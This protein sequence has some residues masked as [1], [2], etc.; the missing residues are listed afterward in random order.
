MMISFD[1]NSPAEAP[2]QKGE[3]RT[4][5]LGQ[6]KLNTWFSENIAQARGKLHTHCKEQQI[7]YQ[8]FE[9]PLK[10]P[11]G[12][13]LGTDVVLVGKE[14][15]DNLL[16][17]VSGTHGV[18]TLVGSG[19]QL[20]WLDANK[21]HPLPGNTAVLIIHGINP[22]GAAWRSRYTE[23]NVDLNRNF[24]NHNADYPP[25]PD[26]VKLHTALS[27]RAID[28]PEKVLAEQT[29]ATFCKDYGEKAYVR[30]L[31]QG[32]YTHKDGLAFGGNSAT[33]SNRTLHQILDIYARHAKRIAVIDYHS[34]IGPYGYG[35]I[36]TRYKEG[37]PG[38]TRCRQWY[39][40][41][42][43]EAENAKDIH[44]PVAGGLCA[45]VADALPDTEVTAILLEYGT[46]AF[47]QA[48][49]TFRR[50][51][52]LYDPS[53]I[54][55]VVEERLRQEIQAF[56]YPVSNDWREMI[57]TRSE[58]IIWQALSGLTKRS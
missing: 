20:A 58:Q 52:P 39:R 21:S 51:A 7:E 15:A 46:Y 28:G 4:A 29:I 53:L 40:E 19:C 44:Y 54:C 57:W 3:T 17:L 43:V 32:Q 6:Q 41:A 9:H 37:M 14:S 22:Y 8:I 35:A 45:G 55:S 31:C 16:I 50:Q 27:C 49:E 42:L 12:E 48:L 23:D 13:N 25:N 30:A 38:L 36:I 56:F 33:W 18:E 24:V 26:Y 1:T 2:L 47:N 5:W 34:G 10:G 11:A